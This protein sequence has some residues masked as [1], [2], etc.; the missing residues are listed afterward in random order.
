M[1]FFIKRIEI[2]TILNEILNLNLDIIK[3]MPLIHYYKGNFPNGD[4]SK[5]DF[6]YD[7]INVLNI[8]FSYKFSKYPNSN[9]LKKY[10]ELAYV[11]RIMK[12]K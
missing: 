3:Y 2:L 5:C 6:L 11:K 8:N 7:S 12:I 1:D 4:Y 10:E 9:I